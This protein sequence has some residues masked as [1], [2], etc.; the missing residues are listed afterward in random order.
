M[1]I[2]YLIKSWWRYAEENKMI[3]KLYI[4]KISRIIYNSSRGDAWMRSYNN[5]GNKYIAKYVV[6]LTE[7]KRK[8]KKRVLFSYLRKE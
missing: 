5:E 1:F 7:E 4:L 2:I 3:L 8:I 6:S